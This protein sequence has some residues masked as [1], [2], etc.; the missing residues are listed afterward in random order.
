VRHVRMLGIGLLAVLATSAIALSAAS[1][2]LAEKNFFKLFVPGCP[3]RH[4]PE[5]LTQ[6][7]YGKTGEG[8]EFKAGNIQV[9]LSKP[10]VLKGGDILNEETGLFTFVGAE[11][12]PTI[13]KVAQELPGGLESIVDPTKLSGT[14]AARYHKIVNEGKTK[15]TVT[16]ELA[17]P[18]SSIY[19]NPFA[20]FEGV[21]TA[22][23]VP[24]Q[25]KLSNPFLGGACY[26]GS[27]AHPIVVAMT[28]GE[29]GALKGNV[30]EVEFHAGGEIVVFHNNSLVNGLYV[31][32]GV[33]GCG[34]INGADEAVNSKSGLPA[35]PGASTV[36]LKGE[37]WASGA[38]ATAEFMNLKYNE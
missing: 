4:V 23:E 29:S 3:L 9:P 28:T 17:G 27:N 25:I 16:V 12:G 21:G 32:P 18:A 37:L 20:I 15:T 11:T 38:L 36:V 26:A 33:Y 35:E 30:G 22:L 6:C 8:S 34:Q 10:I 13:S 24:V 5:A 31:A 1:P 2:A 7:I 19:V 14:E